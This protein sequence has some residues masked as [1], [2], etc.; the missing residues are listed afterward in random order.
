MSRRK[1]SL[2]HE[3]FRIIALS[4]VLVVAAVGF[5]L[6]TGGG[7]GLW[8]PAA[9]S[10]W[11]LTVVFFFRDPQRIPPAGEKLI[12]APADGK[13]ISLSDAFDSP[14]DPPGIRISIFMSVFN[15]HV[16]R[17]PFSG[18][19]ES[20]EHR[21][22]KFKT[23]FKPSASLE[24]E[25]VEVILDSAHG[26]LAYRLIAGLL[27]RRIAFHPVPGDYLKTGQ[28]MGMI[29]FGS[30]VDLFLPHNTRIDAHLGDKVTAGETI[31]G[32]FLG[33]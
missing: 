11:F 27:A 15:V 23:A 7:K 26:K 22:G 20:V 8:L 21:L 28:R 10:I 31:I 14:L 29:R 2:A 18:A 30:R 24:N 32:E 9:T 19:V 17:V 4:A 1:V 5:S 33:S 25:R 12:V 16:N 3:G 13:I 6:L